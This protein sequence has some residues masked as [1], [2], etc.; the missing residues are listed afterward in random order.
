MGF[1]HPS[2]SSTADA[3]TLTKQVGSLMLLPSENPTIATVSDVSKLTGQAFFAHAEN[4][5]KV[6]IYPTSKEAILYRPSINKIVQVGPINTPPPGPQVAGASTTPTPVPSGT[7]TPTPSQVKV[8]VINGTKTS[9]LAASAGKKITES[10]S[11]VTL[12]G[13]GN[14]QNDYDKTV[15]VDLSGKQKNIASQIASVVGGTVGSLPDGEKTQN[16]DILVIIGK[17]YN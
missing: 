7:V 14:A 11:T 2:P 9:G 16:A 1:F 10:I 6:L 17:D 5:D 12:A 4:G 13:T 3:Q 15:V 8:T